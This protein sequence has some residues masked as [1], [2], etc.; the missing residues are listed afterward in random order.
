M[1]YFPHEHGTEKNLVS[2]FFYN[3]IVYQRDFT[4]CSLCPED[5][6]FADSISNTNLFESLEERGNSEIEWFLFV[7]FANSFS[8]FFVSL[9]RRSCRNNEKR[10]TPFQKVLWLQAISQVLYT[11]WF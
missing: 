3:S 4:Q 7:I 1:C 2:S 11:V 6:D 5:V 9:I 10:S 8:K